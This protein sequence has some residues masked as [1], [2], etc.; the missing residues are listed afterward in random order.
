MRRLY[1]LRLVLVFL[2][3]IGISVGCQVAIPTTV[4]PVPATA[5]PTD[6]AATEQ[7]ES[8]RPS[9]PGGP[10][11]A[12]NLKGDSTRGAQVFVN[13]VPCHGEQGKGGVV[14][15][16]SAD[17]TVPALNPIDATMASRDPKVFANNIDL[18]IEHGST[19]DGPNPSLKMPAWGDT[20]GLTPQQIADVIAYIM[21]LNP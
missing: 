18:F 20:N 17:G 9:N 10:G 6:S 14:N 16:G 3:L 21:S 15:A 4:S 11:P 2:L 19:P 5:I 1:S 8:A 12:L 7:A 13:C